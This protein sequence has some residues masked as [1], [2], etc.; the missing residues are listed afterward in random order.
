MDYITDIPILL[1]H[2]INEMFTLNSLPLWYRIR[3]AFVFIISL[4]YFLSPL[5]LIPEALFGIV[6]FIDDLLVILI[7]SIYACQIYRQVIANRQ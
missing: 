2:V 5:D 6:G 1:R 4:L 3:F 7:L